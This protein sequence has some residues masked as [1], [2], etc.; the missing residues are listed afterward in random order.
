MDFNNACLNLQINSPFSVV[1]LKKQYRLMALKY[2]PDKHVPDIDHFY[3]NKFK[4]IQ[5][6]YEYLNTFLE[7]NV[8]IPENK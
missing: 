8:A 5:E 6:S 4:M 2:H 7:D 1:E 3:E